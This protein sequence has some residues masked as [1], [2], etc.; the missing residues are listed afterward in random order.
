MDR[1]IS[2]PKSF[3]TVKK[4]PKHIFVFTVK[5]EQGEE[6]FEIGFDESRERVC[7][8]A[9]LASQIPAVVS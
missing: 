8:D 7:V 9:S 3:G 6:V 1:P 5:V 2:G 4:S